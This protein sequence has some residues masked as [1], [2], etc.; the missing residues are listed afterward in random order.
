MVH[1]PP[2]FRLVV[3]MFAVASSAAAAFMANVVP[4]L[5]ERTVSPVMA[6]TLGGLLGVMQV[7]G[8]ALLMLGVFPAAPVRLVTLSLILQG[9]GLIGLAVVPVGALLVVAVVVFSVGAG[10]TTLARP[11]VVQAVFTIEQAGYLNGCLA[12]WQQLARAAGPILVAWLASTA[13]YAVVYVLLGIVFAVV[14]PVFERVLHGRIRQA[15]TLAAV[16]W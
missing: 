8:R 6:A 16:R 10:L 12:R 9:L 14:A 4:A 13:S 2:G 15:R 1:N 5:S 3:V 7:P 11:H